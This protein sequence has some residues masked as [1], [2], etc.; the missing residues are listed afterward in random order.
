MFT[1]L[2]EQTGRIRKIA[3]RSN[4]RVLTIGAEGM[5]G[6]LQIGESIACDGACLTVVSSDQS[7]FVVE[8]SQETAARTILDSY[9]VG[10][11]INLERA[12][13]LGE[14]LGGHMV[15]G[16]VD[17][18]G[19][20]ARLRQVGESLEVDISFDTAFAPLVIEKG[21]IAI[22]G[23]SLTV[24]TVNPGRLSVNIIPH[25]LQATTVKTMKQGA[26][27]NVE[28]DLIGKYILKSSGLAPKKG[29]T[30]DKLIESG[31]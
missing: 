24:N 22:N 8:A 4:Y 10:S 1:G 19:E 6:E 28:F 9:Q 15:S 20:I 12:V 27:V 13:Q 2:I 29:L 21:S 25:T 23:I 30:R 26:K 3:L 17:T 5:S 7:Q 14:R 31:W 18:V 16:H 11:E